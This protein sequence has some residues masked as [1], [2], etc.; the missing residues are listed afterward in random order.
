MIPLKKIWLIKKKKKE[1]GLWFKLR[2]IMVLWFWSLL[3]SAHTILSH[4]LFLLLS[5]KFQMIEEKGRK[6]IAISLDELQLIVKDIY[7][8][9]I[10]H[11]FYKSRKHWKFFLNQISPMT[12]FL[13]QFLFLE[14]Q[15]CSPMKYILTDGLKSFSSSAVHFEVLRLKSLSCSNL[16]PI[17]YEYILQVNLHQD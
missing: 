8:V 4:M 16:V 14:C 11:S 17:V 1:P 5:P 3:L 12:F 10:H 9:Y 13:S 15:N 2:L 6:K 7:T